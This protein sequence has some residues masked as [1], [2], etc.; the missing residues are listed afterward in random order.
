VCKLQ[1]CE[2]MVLE[3]LK[4]N[5][6]RI[7]PHDML[8]HIIVRL[9]FS[10]EQRLDIRRHAVVFLVLC[11]IGILYRR[12]SVSTPYIQ[13]RSKALRGP[14][15]TVTWDPSVASPRPEVLR[16]GWSFGRACSWGAVYSV[17]S[18]V[19]SPA[20]KSFDAFVFSD[21]LAC[22]WKPLCALSFHTFLSRK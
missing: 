4:W 12:F 10:A 20:A 7:T 11:I 13:W 2:L 21:D 17:S 5:V 8:D 14:G 18:P 16:A 9:P 22:C 1:D 6:S 19:G 3:A 15:S